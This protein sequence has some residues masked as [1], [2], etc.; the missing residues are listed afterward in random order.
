MYFTIFYNCFKAIWVL[1]LVFFNSSWFSAQNSAQKAYENQIN[2]SRIY[3]LLFYLTTKPSS[4]EYFSFSK[5][6]IHVEETFRHVIPDLSVEI[7]DAKNSLP[8]LLWYFYFLSYPE[9]VHY[10]T[11][12]FY[13]TDKNSTLRN[14]IPK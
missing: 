5:L 6:F 13:S 9:I 1:L 12:I 2:F 4:S 7:L 11:V 14:S 3:S 8:E 10:A